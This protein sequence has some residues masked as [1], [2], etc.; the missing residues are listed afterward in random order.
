MSENRN[1]E[2]SRRRFVRNLL[3]TGGMLS[4]TGALTG[5]MSGK[6]EAQ[7][8]T[9][10]PVTTTTAAPTTTTAAPTT[11]VAPTAVPALGA[12]ALAGLT[13]AI[14]AAAAA[15]LKRDAEPE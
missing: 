13:V 6:A 7:V 11:T 8:T 3:V 15:K 14:G 4:A 2:K 1:D 10:P 9:L 5:G 12:V